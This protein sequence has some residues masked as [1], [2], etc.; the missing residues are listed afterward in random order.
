[1]IPEFQRALEATPVGTV[2]GVV[3]TPFGF[4]LILRTK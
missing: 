4:H 1:M 3:E 2:S